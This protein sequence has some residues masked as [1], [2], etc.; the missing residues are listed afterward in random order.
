MCRHDSDNE[1]AGTH[2]ESGQIVLLT[3][4]LWQMIWW[5]RFSKLIVDCRWCS[6]RQVQSTLLV[7]RAMTWLL[8][9]NDKIKHS[10]DFEIAT[11]KTSRNLPESQKT[12]HNLPELRKISHNLPELQKTPHNLPELQKIPHNLPEW[13][14]SSHNLPESKRHPITCPSDKRHPITCPS[15]KDIP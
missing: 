8:Y 12:F 1:R 14:K 6:Q 10:L 11:E 2:L 13:Q 4:L 5:S 7:A 9:N 3:V 15:Q